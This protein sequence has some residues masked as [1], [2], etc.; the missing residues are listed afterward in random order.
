MPISVLE[1]KQ[2][3]GRAGRP[4]YDTFGEAIIIAESGVSSTDLYEHYILGEPE[5]VRSQLINDRALRIH[6]LSI[7]STI[8]GMKQGEIYDLFGTTLCAQHYKRAVITLKID[9]A[10]RYLEDE[11]LIKSKN[12]RYIPTNFGRLSSLLYID[13]LTAVEFKRAIESAEQSNAN[14]NDGVINHTLGFLHLI[15]SCADFYPKFSMRK[16]R[17][18][19]NCNH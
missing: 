1:Y 17:L 10:L 18:R 16:E 14:P 9:T 19:I 8:P 4:K 12:E 5:P 11:N 3:C 13:P 2:L 7:I 15:T 6:V